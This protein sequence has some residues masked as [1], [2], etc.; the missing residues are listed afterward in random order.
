MKSKF[1]EPE[2]DT[3]DGKWSLHSFP[4]DEPPEANGGMAFE[5][6]HNKIIVQFQKRFTVSI[7]CTPKSI[8]EL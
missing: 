1:S 5:K 6:L 4:T 7:A 8:S 2:L 3:T